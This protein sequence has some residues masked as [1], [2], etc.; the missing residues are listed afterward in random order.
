MGFGVGLS[1]LICWLHVVSP[2][3]AAP[4]VIVCSIISQIQTLP[5]I[6]HAIVWRQ[7]LPFISGGMVGVPIE[8][9]L[10]GFVSL[11]VFKSIV[12][13]LLIVSCSFLLLRKSPVVVSWGGKIGDVAVGLGGGI[14]GGLAGLSGSFPM[15]W[16]SLKG[17]GKDEKRGVIQTLNLSVLLFSVTFQT[18][19]GFVTP[20]VGRLTMVALP[21]ILL[22]AWVG[23]KRTIDWA[24]VCSIKLF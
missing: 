8:T 11:P 1:A 16:A 7:V 4:L 2:V 5:A 14:F 24:K 10:L 17:W 20:D 23:R 22:G 6:W 3:V 13:C 15:I 18:L 21:G 12:G 19:S 9:I